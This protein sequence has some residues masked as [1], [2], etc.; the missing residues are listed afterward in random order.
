MQIRKFVLSPF[1]TNGYLLSEN[2]EA[3]FIDP[4]DNPIEV[5][6]FIQSE[7]LNLTNIL[8][9]HM[10]SDHFY[11]AAK[12]AEMT[13]AQ[14]LGCKD[15]AFLVESEIRDAPR[16]GFPPLVEEFAFTPIAPGR[17]QF[18]GKTCDVLP[19]PGHT[20]GSVTFSFP[21]EGIAF[22]GD[23]IFFR[24]IGRTD[25][26]GGNFDALLNSVRT[27]IFNLPDETILYPGH[28]R[29]TKVGDEKAHNSYFNR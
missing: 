17:H 29:S 25:F 13:G 5:V 12:L 16:W 9:T 28:E 1:Q 19:T 14:I 27:Q 11:G 24:N 20:P 22:V 23:L 3:I 10:H 2:G 6:N 4:G 21:E 7:G 18:I 15:D 8:I 26:P